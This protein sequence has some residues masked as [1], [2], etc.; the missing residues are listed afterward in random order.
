MGFLGNVFGVW[1]FAVIV[2]RIDDKSDDEQCPPRSEIV[3][4]L[5]A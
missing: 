2:L 4:V 3:V 1:R 5:Q